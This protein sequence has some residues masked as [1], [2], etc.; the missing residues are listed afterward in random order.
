[1]GDEKHLEGK[2]WTWLSK[3]GIIPSLL[4]MI[5]IIGWMTWPFAGWFPFHLSSNYRKLKDE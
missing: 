1:M 4:A 2:I 5:A 3:I